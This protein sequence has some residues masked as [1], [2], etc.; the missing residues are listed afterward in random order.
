MFAMLD[1]KSSPLL[2]MLQNIV[3][4][5]ISLVFLPLDTFIL[6][7]SYLLNHIFHN[8][9]EESR[10][11]ARSK[12]GFQ[13]RTILVT[14]VG[15]TKGLVLARSFYEAGHKVLGADFEANGSP[16]CGRASK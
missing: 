6:G 7:F 11:N 2:H 13:P 4:I 8:K 15:M 5:A 10:R 1:S 12:P 16:V 14:G 9:S 3:L